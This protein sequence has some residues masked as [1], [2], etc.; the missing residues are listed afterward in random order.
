[1]ALARR[2]FLRA[3]LLGWMIPLAAALSNCDSTVD[4]DS[5]PVLAFLKRVLR[6]VL[7]SR[8]R[9]VR[10]SVWRVHLIAALM[11]G[12]LGSGGFA[13]TSFGESRKKGTKRATGMP[14]HKG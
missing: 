9:L 14:G 8:F 2:D 4:A 7:V 10:F 1:M 13:A 12:K 11:F 3:A 6:R 5:A